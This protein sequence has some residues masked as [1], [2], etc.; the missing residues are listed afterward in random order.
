MSARRRDRVWPSC[1]ICGNPAGAPRRID[2]ISLVIAVLP[3][4]RF[5]SAVA[6]RP[7][8][9]RIATELTVCQDTTISAVI[10]DMVVPSIVNR[11]NTYRAQRRVVDNRGAANLPRC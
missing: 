4:R 3:R 7:A 1:A 9:A 8:V 2:S 5:G 11:R 10:A 6:I